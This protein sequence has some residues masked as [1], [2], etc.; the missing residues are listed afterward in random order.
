MNNLI[1]IYPFNLARDI[2]GSEEDAMKIYVPGIPLALATLSE[3]E[4]DVLRKRYCD[5]MTLKAIGEIQEVGGERIRQIEAK[6]LH[7]LRH[8]SRMK[9]YKAVPVAELVEAQ[10][11]YRR[12]NREHELLAKAVAA[13]TANPAGQDT[14]VPPSGA[15]VTRLTPLDELGLSVRTYNCLRRAGVDTL[16][17][18]ADMTEAELLQIRNLGTYIVTGKQIGRAHV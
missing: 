15:I 10:A 4:A 2:F 17:E 8:P 7:K 16:E 1:E 6:A 11:S 14:I 9:I 12:L 13:L 3:R 18:V 5:K